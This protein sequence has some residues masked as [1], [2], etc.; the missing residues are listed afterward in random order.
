MSNGREEAWGK[1]DGWFEVGSGADGATKAKRAR[2]VV[3]WSRRGG[4]DRAQGTLID[5]HV[6]ERRVHARDGNDKT[7]GGSSRHSS[8]E[9]ERMMNV[10]WS[11]GIARTLNGMR[12]FGDERSCLGLKPNRLLF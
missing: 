9:K 8:V 5:R 7:S 12:A 1:V 4:A 6:F 3:G 10:A 11:S 2:I